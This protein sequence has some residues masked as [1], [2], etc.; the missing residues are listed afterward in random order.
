VTVVRESAAASEEVRL[1][2]GQATINPTGVWHAV[3][4]D[5]RARILAITAGLGTEHR[6]R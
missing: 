4:M 1:G 2:A 5:G 6:P 3:D